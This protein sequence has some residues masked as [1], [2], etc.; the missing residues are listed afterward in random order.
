MASFV[1]G[2]Q[3]AQQVTCIE[4]RTHNLILLLRCCSLLEKKPFYSG[5][6]KAFYLPLV[7]D[8]ICEIRPECKQEELLLVAAEILLFLSCGPLLLLR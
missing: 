8:I 1:P 4:S 7:L 2:I 3:R 6:E 5:K